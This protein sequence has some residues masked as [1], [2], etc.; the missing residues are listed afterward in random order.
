MK[1]KNHIFDRAITYINA[2]LSDPEFDNIWGNTHD[3]VVM[4]KLKSDYFDVSN[5]NFMN[6]YA[7]LDETERDT[8]I[9]YLEKNA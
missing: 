7:G 9:D 3:S 6:F 5:G 1:H 8:L 4:K 2:K